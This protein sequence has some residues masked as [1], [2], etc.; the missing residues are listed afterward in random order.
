MRVW[1][2]PTRVF[3][4]LLVCAFFSALLSSWRDYYLDYHTTAGYIAL[5]LIIF[6]IIWGFA[7]SRYSRFSEFIRGWPEVR[8][9]ISKALQRQPIRYI[10]H[11]PAVGW[12]VIALLALTIITALTGIVIYA[13]EEGR[14]IWRGFISYETASYVRT[15]HPYIAYFATLVV[16]GHICAALFHDFILKEH[17]IVSMITG[18]KESEEESGKAMTPADKGPLPARLLAL[19]LVI[20]MA[21][22]ALTFLPSGF[23]KEYIPPKVLGADGAWVKVMENELWKDECATSCH[24]AFFPTLLPEASWKSIMGGLEEHFGDDAS[25]DKEDTLEIETY[26]LSASAERSNSE[27]SRKILA[28]LK[29]G[30]APLRVTKTPYWEEKHSYIRDEIFKRES[31]V[32]RSNCVACHPGSDAGSFEDGHIK[33][34]R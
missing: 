11:N 1:D 16:A 22:L 4:W 5:G 19:A 26:L 13:G 29:T 9:F 6:R 10:G 17:I 31:V 21:V 30:E 20:I 28:S 18:K 32:S 24:G 3:H 25:L 33:I 34:P 15:A 23:S 27:A 8:S 14:G 12:V 7:G 2:I